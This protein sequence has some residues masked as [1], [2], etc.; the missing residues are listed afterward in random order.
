MPI[1]N[2]YNS[3]HTCCLLTEQITLVPYKPG[4]EALSIRISILPG[5]T[6][7][8]QPLASRMEA[9]RELDISKLPQHSF[10]VQR[11]PPGVGLLHW[12]P[13][14]QCYGCC[15]E[16]WPEPHRSC[17]QKLYIKHSA[18]DLGF[19]QPCKHLGCSSFRGGHLGKAGL[20]DRQEQAAKPQAKCREVIV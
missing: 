10:K 13:L 5:R 11:P 20:W 17:H 7:L 18:K 9:D 6:S 12:S 15:S 16:V 19:T 2:I 3:F 4:L 14:E 8:P 1:E